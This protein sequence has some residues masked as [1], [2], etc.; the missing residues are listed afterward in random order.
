MLRELRLPEQQ[1][2]VRVASKDAVH[3]TLVEAF[4]GEEVTHGDM[5]AKEPLV[6]VATQPETE[7]LTWN[8]IQRDASFQQYRKE[9]GLNVTF[10]PK[11]TVKQMIFSSLG[12]NVS[13]ITAAES[14]IPLSRPLSDALPP[15]SADAWPLLVGAMESMDVTKHTLNPDSPLLRDLLPGGEANALSTI[16]TVLTLYHPECEME[17]LDPRLRARLLKTHPTVDASVVQSILEM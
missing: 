17:A 4:L 16:Q 2:E 3:E 7:T 15:V 12:L 13:D 9:A 14:I 8:D 6:F 1:Q 10:S 5:P 11:K